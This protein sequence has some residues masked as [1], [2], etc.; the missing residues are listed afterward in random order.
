M[1]ISIL[2]ESIISITDLKKN[3][4]TVSETPITCVLSHNSPAF[5]TVSNDKMMDLLEL[6]FNKR[7]QDE[8]I[9]KLKNGLISFEDFING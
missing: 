2:S 6:E 1:P 8:M 4:T 7:K 3:P 5:Y 9:L